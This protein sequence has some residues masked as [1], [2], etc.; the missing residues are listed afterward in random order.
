[1]RHGQE[2]KIGLL[3]QR[4][5]GRRV[6]KSQRAQFP[7]QAVNKLGKRLAGVLPGGDQGDERPGCRAR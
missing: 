7:W 3:R 4:E 2:K 1:M 5:V 6:D